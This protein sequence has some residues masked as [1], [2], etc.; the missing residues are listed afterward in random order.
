MKPFSKCCI[1][2]LAIFP[3][4]ALAADNNPTNAPSPLPESV[5]AAVAAA[6]CERLIALHRHY[7]ADAAEW[8]A[9]VAALED[10]IFALPDC[11][12]VEAALVRVEPLRGVNFFDRAQPLGAAPAGR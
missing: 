5:A 12:R 2:L 11:A 6:D 4:A 3:L 8:A 10:A 9:V 7:R 1:R